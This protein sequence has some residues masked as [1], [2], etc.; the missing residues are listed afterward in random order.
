MGNSVIVKP[1]EQSSYSLLYIAE[2]AV[3]AGIPAGVLNVITGYGEEAGKAIACH[4]DLGAVFFTGSSEVGKKILEYS[5]Q[6]N[7]KKVGLEC[8]GKSAFILSQNYQDLPHAAET[9]ARNMFYNQGQICSAPSRLVIHES[10]KEK[11]LPLLIAA[12]KQYVP[13]NPLDENTQVGTVVSRSQFD[14][15]NAFIKK[16]EQKDYDIIQIGSAEDIGDNQLSVLP[17]IIDGV[18]P[19]DYLAQEE[20]FGPMLVVITYESISEAVSITNNSRYGLAASI[21][22]D[23]LGEALSTSRLL[24]AGIVHINSYGDDD[25][26]IPFGGVKQSGI[27]KD[28]SLHAFDEYCELKSTVIAYKKIQ[29]HG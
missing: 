15:I 3:Q 2:L 22:T 9:L 12:S 18:E 6:S 11:F 10:I 27:G 16:A 5:G 17:R 4:H 29:S 24:E 7:M 13:G 26:N 1:A 21:W 19:D 23:D 20:I 8:G 28:K 25:N 14:R